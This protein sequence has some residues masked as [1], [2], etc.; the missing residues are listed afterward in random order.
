[1]ARF[2]LPPGSG[3]AEILYEA[4]HSLPKEQQTLSVF[5]KLPDLYRIVR[6]IAFSYKKQIPDYYNRL[7]QLRRLK[8]Y[9]HR[10]ETRR[11]E[12]S[13]VTAEVF[14]D[15]PSM[16]LYR[17]YFSSS[18]PERLSVL[19]HEVTHCLQALFEPKRKRALAKRRE[20]SGAVLKYEHDWY[21]VETLTKDIYYEIK[22]KRKLGRLRTEQSVANYIRKHEDYIEFKLSDKKK[23]IKKIMT[24]VFE[25]K[26][27]R[28]V[29]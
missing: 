4:V 7:R 29:R 14:F 20:D 21:E 17:L 11:D 8:L 22:H 6:N 23:A 16:H 13:F 1:M 19:E 2:L 3:A 27:K 26:L 12:E 28:K 10:D 25:R 24:T 18:K 9:L 15:P 5:K